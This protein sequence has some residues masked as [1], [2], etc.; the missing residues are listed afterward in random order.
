MGSSAW[1]SV[2]S[3]DYELLG[4]F[5]ACH[6]VFENY[7]TYYLKLHYD[8]DWDSAKL[9]FGMKDICLGTSLKILS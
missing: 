5:L 1:K 8:L 6:L 4:Y 7:L 3:I 2:S 9:N